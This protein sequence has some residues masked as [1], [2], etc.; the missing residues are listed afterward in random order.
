MLP[1]PRMDSIAED[2]EREIAALERLGRA[3]ELKDAQGRLASVQTAIKAVPAV[4]RDLGV[5]DAP[6]RC[7]VFVELN[8]GIRERR[9]DAR[10]EDVQLGRRVT[11]VLEAK[12]VGWY[13]ARLLGWRY[14]R[15]RL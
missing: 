3:D 12:N 8:V 13:A 2:L 9:L 5:L 11:E 4:S 14:L 6:M 15:A 1:S 10:G 7:A